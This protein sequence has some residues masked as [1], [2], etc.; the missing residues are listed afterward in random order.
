MVQRV[1][2]RSCLAERHHGRRGRALLGVDRVSIVYACVAVPSWLP[3]GRKIHRWLGK[4]ALLGK[5]ALAGFGK[6]QQVCLPVMEDDEFPNTLPEV[7]RGDPLALRTRQRC[8]GWRGLGSWCL[9]HTGL[10]L[11]YDEVSG[12]YGWP[13]QQYI[14]LKMII[15][16][17]I[18]R[19]KV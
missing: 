14:N 10:Y 13:G 2:R 19:E 4:R 8:G 7:R 3:D 6:A 1:Q 15:I 11:A 17:T 18:N 12:W 5:N 16:V 9:G